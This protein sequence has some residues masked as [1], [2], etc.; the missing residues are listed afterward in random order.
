[1][2]V[3]LLAVLLVLAPVTTCETY[4]QSNLSR[5]PAPA[6]VTRPVQ[7]TTEKGTFLGLTTVTASAALRH[8]LQIPRGQGLV[9]D[10]IWPASPAAVAGIQVN[11]VLVKMDDQ[12]LINPPQL[13]VLVRS[14]NPGE[15]IELTLIRQTQPVQIRVTLAQA[16]LPTIEEEAMIMRPRILGPAGVMQGGQP[17]DVS[18]YGEMANASEVTFKDDLYDIVVKIDASALPLK[19]TATVR[20]VGSGQVLFSGGINTPEERASVRAEIVERLKQMKMW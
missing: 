19:K 13:A 11:D 18:V 10:K 3:A 4:A 6:E 15:Q 8:Q 17:Y 12:L 2:K 20:S 7:I 1:M 16:F 5:L 14:K 9:V